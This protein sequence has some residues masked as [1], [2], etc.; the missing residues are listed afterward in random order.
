MS[1]SSVG[2]G[3]DVFLGPG[4]WYFGEAGC[5]VRTTL[6]S[7]VAFTLWH[8]KRRIGG[9]CHYMLPRR[10]EGSKG[11][12]T[13]FAA[14]ALE[15]LLENARSYRTPIEEYEVKL[16]GGAEMFAVS[17]PDSVA[18]QNI[19]MARDLV[20]RYGLRVKA[21]SLGGTRYRQIVFDIA[22]GNVWLK[23]GPGPSSRTL[24]KA[25]R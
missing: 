22:S 1:C 13:R 20:R 23:H 14:E 17:R 12:A 4:E 2:S 16:F 18:A 3:Y 9:M 6:G 19:A 7:C 25:R 10:L 24:A 21:H 15:A 5:R 11:L 8:P